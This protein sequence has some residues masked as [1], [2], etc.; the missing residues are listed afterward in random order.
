MKQNRV[1]ITGLGA[2]T[3]LGNTV[4]STWE[5]VVAGK[6]G[7]GK[8]TRVDAT[9][10][11][12]VVAAELK[13]FDPGHYMD[14]KEARKMDRFTQYA[15]ASAIMA[16]EDA[17][18]DINESNADRIGVWIGSGIGGMETYE[19]Q[20]AIFQEKGHRRVSPFFV[21]MLIPDMASGQ[22][23]ITLGAKGIN[24]CTVTA[25]ASGANSIGDAFKVIER[26][27]ADVMI[28]GGCEAPI[29]NMAMA[30][31]SAAKALSTNPDPATASRPFDLNRDGFVMGEGGAIL[32]LESLDHAQKRGAAIYAEIVG[33][34]ATGDAYHI[35]APAPEGEG[36]VR[37]MRMALKDAGLNPE[38]IDYMNAH[39]TST[40]YN[41]KY[42]TLAI[43]QVFGEYAT[44]LAV[45]STKS[46][47]GHLLGAAGAIEA[48]FS[49]KA[50]VDG[51]IP[52]T[53]NYHTPD[54]EC[55]LDYVPNEARKQEVR[56][57]LSN[58]LGFGGHNATL[59]FKKFN[60]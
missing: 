30:G 8:L 59:V 23:S 22:V 50:I 1:V 4:A 55:D 37:A 27:D 25:C 32:V 47:T 6:S 34:G 53:I 29:T 54:P 42:E 14:K 13:D 28:T 49:V 41:D 46:M 52:P 12:T 7:I 44:K 21:P 26:G 51:I 16:V 57:V 38:D 18:L 33:Y 5:N 40:H 3:P 11:P 39:G 48:I 15:V 19:Q 60:G 35:T 17:K 36:G 10:F 56:A 31:F 9:Q 43:K 58:S 24:S 20:F 2:V 45:S